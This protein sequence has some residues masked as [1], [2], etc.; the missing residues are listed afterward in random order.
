MIGVKAVGVMLISA[1][2]IT[3]AAAARMLTNRFD[4]TLIFSA[5]IACLSS[6]AGL[7]VSYHYDT[8]AGATIIMICSL[9]FFVTWMCHYIAGRKHS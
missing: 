8:P 4:L 5:I 9:V 7:Y 2:M 6:I 3:P 1:L